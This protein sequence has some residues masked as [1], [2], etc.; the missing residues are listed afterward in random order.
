MHRSSDTI[1]GFSR[2]SQRVLQWMLLSSRADMTPPID[3][4]ERMSWAIIPKTKNSHRNV[5]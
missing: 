5:S 3:D 1:D 2:L 4:K